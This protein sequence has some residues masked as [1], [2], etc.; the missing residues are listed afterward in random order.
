MIP[1]AAITAWGVDHP[2]PSRAAIEQDLLLA[3]L[4]VAIYSNVALADELVFRGGTCLHQLHLPRPLRYSEDLDFVRR[5]NDGIG[6]VFDALREVAAQI[7]LDVAA[8]DIREIPKMR[9]RAAASDEPATTLRV[10]IEINT[11]ETSPARELR[12]LAFDVN[13]SW[14]AGAAQVLT[15]DPA[16]LVATKL[17]ALYQ[18][19]KGRDLFDLWLA[20]TELALDP[21]VIVECFEPYR[22]PGYTSR[23]ATANLRAKAADQAFRTDLDLLVYPWP[24]GYDIDV[25]AD[26]VITELLE[27]LWNAGSRSRPPPPA[28]PD[29]FG[30]PVPPV[31]ASARSVRATRC[32]AVD[33]R[34]GGRTGDLLSST[35]SLCVSSDESCA[36]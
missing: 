26:L 18:R 15:F 36:E 6:P 9:L 10:K 19:K 32:D 35:E 29:L 33:T 12:R 2:W 4:I 16:E 22:P 5:S 13:N 34:C 25:A 3:R 20:L 23:L 28:A 30:H 31:R 27:R 17:R 1:S 11:Y 7:G 8:T 21:N 24:A 14:F